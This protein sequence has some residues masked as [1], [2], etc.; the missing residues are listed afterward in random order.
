MFKKEKKGGWVAMVGKTYVMYQ[1][2]YR[3]YDLCRNSGAGSDHER[4][5]YW[6]RQD[7]EVHMSKSEYLSRSESSFL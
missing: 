7:L 6:R 3:M 4:N 1:M 5:A 2:S